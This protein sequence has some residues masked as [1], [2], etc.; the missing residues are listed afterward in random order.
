ME[1]DTQASIVINANNQPVDT[2]GMT[3]KWT[4]LQRREFW[5]MSLH[6]LRCLN[7]V[8]GAGQRTGLVY[9]SALVGLFEGRAVTV[10]DIANM[11]D[12]DRNTTLRHARFLE[13][14]GWCK[15]TKCG[16]RTCVEVLTVEANREFRRVFDDVMERCVNTVR[17]TFCV[18]PAC[19]PPMCSK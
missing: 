15:L 3:R 12:M 5:L 11:C 4:P 18:C 10:S 14:A 13:K 6:T 17:E 9:V 8:P 16:K 19:P 1:H 2:D 7:I